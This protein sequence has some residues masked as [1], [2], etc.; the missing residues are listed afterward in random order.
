MGGS[1]S[2]GKLISRTCFVTLQYL[3][4]N[5]QEYRLGVTAR[6]D[7]HLLVVTPLS[8]L[9]RN[10]IFVS[11]SVPLVMLFQ[12]CFWYIVSQ[13]RPIAED[14]M[15]RVLRTGKRKSK[16]LLYPCQSL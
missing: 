9:A 1:P 16:F 5:T 10:V 14:E 2:Q 11:I 13:V 4:Y 12:R 15:F 6:E 3:H 7:E 8:D